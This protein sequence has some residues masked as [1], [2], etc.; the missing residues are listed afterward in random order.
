[1]VTSSAVVGSSAIRMSERHRDHHALAL[2]AR[3]LVRI[4]IEPALRMRDTHQLQQLQRPRPCR[5]ARQALMLAQG[6]GH[7][8]ADPEERIERGH[9]LLEDHREFF[10]A[11]AVQDRGRQLEQVDLAIADRAGGFAIAG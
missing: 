3:K 4:G 2:P 6:G 8:R 7:L 10:A 1:M 9:R 5:L 11:I